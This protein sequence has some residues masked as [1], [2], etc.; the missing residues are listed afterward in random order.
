MAPLLDVR[1]GLDE[2]T[3]EVDHLAIDGDEAQV[4]LHAGERLIQVDGLGDVVNRADTEAFELTL[5][6]RAGSDED[7]RN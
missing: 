1:A 4:G 7:N 6:G 2:A 3:L 5:F